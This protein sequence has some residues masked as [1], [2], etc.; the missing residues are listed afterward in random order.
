MERVKNRV[1]V[2]GASDNS[3]SDNVTTGNVTADL[4][5]AE[6]IAELE[7][8]LIT[9]AEEKGI[10]I[11]ALRE[12]LAHSTANRLETLAAV[13]EKA[14]EKARKG[15]ENAIENSVRKYERAVEKLIEL[16]VS[17]NVTGN[18]TALQKL[19]EKIKD[20][21]NL[22]FIEKGPTTGGDTE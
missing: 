10:D 19:P 7:D 4:D 20:R 6:R 13:Y 9:L 12:K 2:K 22:R 3:T 17:D 21:L 15:L 1:R 14:P 11:T 16:N 8:E 5:Y 18:M